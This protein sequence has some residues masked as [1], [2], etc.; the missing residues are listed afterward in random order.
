MEHDALGF[1]IHIDHNDINLCEQL[2][3]AM[4]Y[5]HKNT[6]TDYHE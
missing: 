1:H 4:I 2:I 5:I 6:G 3:F